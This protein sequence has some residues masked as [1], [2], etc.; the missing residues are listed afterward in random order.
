MV[1]STPCR[2]C[3][4]CFTAWRLQRKACV[5]QRGQISAHQS[6]C[7]RSPHWPQGQKAKLLS[8]CSTRGPKLRLRCSYCHLS[9][10]RKDSKLPCQELWP[11]CQYNTQPLSLILPVNMKG[12]AKATWC[13]SILTQKIT[14]SFDV[15]EFVW[16]FASEHF[17]CNSLKCDKELHLMQMNAYSIGGWGG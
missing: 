5:C 4:L 11:P 13:S 8:R 1:P 15:C 9:P 10:K 14:I 16:V 2:L 3:K 6:W 17:I 12:V 7:L